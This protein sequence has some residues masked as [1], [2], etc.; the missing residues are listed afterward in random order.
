M[1]VRTQNRKKL[2][3]SIKYEIIGHK[4]EEGT[5][6]IIADD[7]DC[8]GTYP[9]EQRAL[10]VL[11]EIQQAIIGVL[12]I[13]HELTYKTP[14][15]ENELTVTHEEIKQLPTVYEMPKE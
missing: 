9:T 14:Y 2:L 8:L 3:D 7:Y 1:W 12:I 5:F 6:A 13:P 4:D 10:E 11:D 15:F